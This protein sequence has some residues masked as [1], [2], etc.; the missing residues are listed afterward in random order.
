VLDARGRMIGVADQIATDRIVSIDGSRI[1]EVSELV[2]VLAVHA[3]GERVVV[4]VR[5]GSATHR[6]DVTLGRQP[7][8]AVRR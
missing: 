6:L 7:E 3:A 5:R 8:M 4:T 2:A 1:S